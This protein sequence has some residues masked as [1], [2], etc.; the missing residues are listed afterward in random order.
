M[1]LPDRASLLAHIE[2]RL[3]LAGLTP[4]TSLLASLATYLEV[5][6]DERRHMARELHA[7]IPQS[8]LTVLPRARH[9]T[10]IEF[11]DQIASQ[12]RALIG[13]AAAPHA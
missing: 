10:P 13:R 6:E 11:P 7:A 4:Q 5:Q 1:T 9:L 12:L 2:Q 3:A 8:T